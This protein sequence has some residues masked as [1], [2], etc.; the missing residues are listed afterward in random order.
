MRRYTKFFSVYAAIGLMVFGIAEQ[1]DAQ[2]RNERETRDIVRS[3]NSKIDDFQYSLEYQLKSSSAD[4]RDT[5]TI[6][7]DLRD[8]Q[9]K[10][11]AFDENLMAKRENRD[12]VSGLLRSAQVVDQFLISNPQNGKLQTD[13]TAIRTLL[14]RLAN[15]YGVSPD[16]NA[17]NNSSY[18][19][20]GRDTG[21][22]PAP[23]RSTNFNSGLTGTYR[24]DA[25]KSENTADIIANSKVGNAQRQDL[26]SKLE[27]PEQIALDVRGNQ[28]TLASSKA[29][30][31]TIIADGREKTENAGGRTIRVRATLRGEELTL[32]SLGGET[33]Y[34]IT[35]APTDS[36]RT[37]KVT[38]RITT[39]YLTETVFADSVY[40]KTDVVAGL[41]IEPNTGGNASDIGTYSSNDP[42]DK[43]GTYGST[44][45]I[46]T[47]RIG[48][49]TVPN[50]TIVTAV[51]E[52][53]IN[54]K[55][56]QNNDRFRMTVQS[57]DEYRGAVIEGYLS[58]VGRSGRISGSSNL[59]FNFERITMRDGKA[60]D[61]AGSLQGIKD[62][63]G[64]TVKVDTEGTVRGDSQ[65]KE[66]VKRGG[67]GGAAGAI[68]GA[69]AG[70]AKGAAIG[71]IIGGGAGAGS[72]IYQGRDDVQLLKGSTI[73]VQSS[74]P[75]RNNQQL[76]E[77]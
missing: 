70:G 52:N 46:N 14:D 1:A 75:I 10:V 23:G 51:L 42:A 26:E 56:S 6:S 47:P 72:V 43:I 64:K 54:T 49:F 57:P 8:F 73:T 50:G 36:G 71:A 11:N 60:Y 63:Y 5:G 68:I 41:G 77:N 33:D 44:P 13:W 35:F 31:I 76:S 65:T 25:A 59:T 48:E 2:R 20:T 45:S 69:I 15:S 53:E 27:A 58:G 4:P 38:R 24:L 29:A 62:Q 39:E 40:N 30:P 74:S 18:P 7:A 34:T 16:W 32:S 17:G 12:D 19:N 55:V 3:L 21:T 22:Y 37:M 61:F 9:E 28:V 66:T 67:I